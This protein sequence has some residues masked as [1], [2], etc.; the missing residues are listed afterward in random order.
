MIRKDPTFK[1]YESVQMG[2]DVKLIIVLIFQY[3]RLVWLFW[4]DVNQL[5]DLCVVPNQVQLLAFCFAF[6][7]Q[8]CGNRLPA[9]FS[10]HELRQQ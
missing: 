5:L 10:R 7:I 3:I 4:F 2:A 9:I 8:L 6:Q 1:V